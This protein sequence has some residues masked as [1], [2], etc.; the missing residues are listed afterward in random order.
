[1]GVGALVG[2]AAGRFGPSAAKG[3]LPVLAAAAAFV[4]VAVGDT[5]GWASSASGTFRDQAG[6]DV[7]ATSI[8][9][10]LNSGSLDIQGRDFPVREAYKEDFSFMLLVFLAIGV[11]AA[12]RICRSQLEAVGAPAP[13]FP[14]P[15]GPAAW[16]APPAQPAP[17]PWDSHGNPTGPPAPISFEKPVPPQV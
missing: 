9:R 11:A 3:T 6:L 5:Y 1:M 15:A 8:F 16:P 13:A 10:G 4:S 2:F 7:S 14:P 12:F 17:S